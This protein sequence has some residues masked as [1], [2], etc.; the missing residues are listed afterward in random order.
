MELK[1]RKPAVERY[2]HDFG[3]LKRK[4]GSELAIAVKRRCDQLRAAT[5][6]RIY[7]ST[8]LGKPH[9]LREN[10]K[11]CYGIS[12]SG[13]IRLVVKPDVETLDPDSLEH[14]DTI[15]I[16]GVVDYHGHKLEWLIP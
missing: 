13:N 15:T 1:Y 3:L 11:G 2:F 12:I 10:L 6:F 16:E 5:N 4:I 8:Q 14:C 7:L 9:P